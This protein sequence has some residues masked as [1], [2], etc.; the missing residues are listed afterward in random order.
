MS[1]AP[2]QDKG[3]FHVGLVAMPWQ[4]MHRPSVQLGALKSYLTQNVRNIQVRN[5][6]PYLGVAKVLGTELYHL[7]SQHVWLSEALYAGLLFPEK[8]DELRQYIHSQKK[9]FTGHDLDADTL[10][11]KLDMQLDYWLGKQDWQSLQLVGFTV[12][13]Q[14]LLASLLAAKRLKNI[15]PDLPIV[16]GGSSCSFGVGQTLLEQ[17][18]QIDYLIHGEGELPLAQLCTT[19][20]KGKGELGA[21]ILAREDNDNAATA[22]TTRQVALLSDLP[23]PDYD[24]YFQEMAALF[25]DSSF[26]P[27]LPVEFSRGCWWGKCTFCNLN[28]QWQGYRWKR[29]EQM[30]SEVTYLSER[31]G[32]LD[33]SFTDNALPVKDSIAFFQDIAATGHDYRFFAEIRVNQRGETL[34]TYAKGGLATVQVGI[35]AL[36]QSLLDRMQKGTSVIDNLALMKE[37]QALGTRLEGNLIMEFPQSTEAEVQ[38]TLAALDFV[39]PFAPLATASFF[40]GQGSPVDCAPQKYG[41]KAQVH[42]PYNKKL[43]P[44]EILQGLTLLIKDYRGD[45]QLQRRQWRPVAKKVAAWQQFH[46]RRKEPALYAP[47][48]SCRDNGTVLLIRQEL[49]GQP[50]LHHRMRGLSRK[51]YLACDGICDKESLL[52]QFPQ[53]TGEQ[54]EKFLNELAAKRLLFIQQTRYLALAVHPR[55]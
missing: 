12:C 5:L 55:N 28:L 31:H 43:F 10:W 49:P 34:A 54:L 8:Q 48:L 6:H 46:D 44:K 13:F 11:Q 16:F 39:L 35:E 3:L 45:R 30:R 25:G 24:D 53:V 17:F 4:L 47:P 20:K 14:Q 40:L 21:G 26:I 22:S 23:V 36:S 9:Q 52:E 38:E 41:I 19:L 27:E 15:Y 42:H 2:R 32:C 37:C 33:F 7:I 51:I 18:S 1:I 29:A 50:T